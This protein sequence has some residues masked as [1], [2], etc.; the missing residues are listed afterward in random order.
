MILPKMPQKYPKWKYLI[1]LLQW[2]LMPITFI[3]FGAI[4]AIEAQTRLAL[5]PKHHLGFFV[6]PKERK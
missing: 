6:T 5:G 4:P 2:L 1:M 3:V